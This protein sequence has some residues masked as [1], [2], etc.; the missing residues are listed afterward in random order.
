M[1]ETQTDTIRLII[2]DDHEMVRV[3]LRT[4]LD[5]FPSVSVV[6]EAG[7]VAEAIKL[8][9]ELLP[10]VI[11]LDVRLGKESGIT[12]CRE[13]QRLTP[14]TRILV[15][16]SFSDE[17]AIFDAMEAGADGYLLKQV[18]GDALVRAISDVA[19]GRAV[20]DPS[21]SRVLSRI[22]APGESTRGRN[23]DSLTPQE[24]KILALVAEGKTNKEIA[25][26]LGLSDKTVKNYFSNILHRLGMARRSQAAAFY[27]RHQYS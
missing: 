10:E 5:R 17:A 27:I 24:R 25:S 19:A 21:V 8:G 1:T 26:I 18:D 3:G 22:D 14:Q 16:T 2:V 9:T 23:L 7:T 13:L 11:L 6:G 20:L 12:V 15:L 4:M